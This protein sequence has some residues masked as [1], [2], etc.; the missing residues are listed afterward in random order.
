MFALPRLIS[1]FVAITCRIIFL[2]LHHLDP[3][4]TLHLHTSIGVLLEHNYTL[5]LPCAT[6]LREK[7]DKEAKIY[8]STDKPFIY[9]RDTISGNKK[10]KVKMII[11]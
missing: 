5:F 4:T 3:S 2:A 11:C 6:M 10:L 7:R 8:Y 9:N 1:E